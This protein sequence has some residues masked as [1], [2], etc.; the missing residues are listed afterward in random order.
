MGKNSAGGVASINMK[1]GRSAVKVDNSDVSV[2]M[3]VVEG[4]ETVGC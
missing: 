1:A 3:V 4:E 2:S